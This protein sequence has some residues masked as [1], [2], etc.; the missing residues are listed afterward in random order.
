MKEINI[1]EF[2]KE[3]FIEIIKELLKLNN[4][5]VTSKLVTSLGI[6]R[7]YLKIMVEKGLLKKVGTGIYMS[8]DGKQDDYFIFSLFAFFGSFSSRF[9]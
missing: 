8:V 1:N 9:F 6:H 4:G 7:M 5:Y 3:S 2:K